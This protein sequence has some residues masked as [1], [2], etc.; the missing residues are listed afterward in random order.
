MLNTVTTRC[1]SCNWILGIVKASPQSWVMAQKSVIRE[2][3]LHFRGY[4]RNRSSPQQATFTMAIRQ[5]KVRG[6]IYIVIDF[7]AVHAE[8]APL[9]T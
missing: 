3:Y 9:D 2:M 6:A 5:E 1:L 4:G 7:D 8:P